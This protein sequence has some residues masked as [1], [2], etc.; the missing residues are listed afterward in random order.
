MWKNEMSYK[1]KLKK[2]SS[3]IFLEDTLSVAQLPYYQWEKS[4]EV[5][6]EKTGDLSVVS[7]KFI[8][9]ILFCPGPQLILHQYNFCS[10]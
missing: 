6:E 5:Q 7:V 3:I 4:A 9:K 2:Q 10:I 1:D 8:I